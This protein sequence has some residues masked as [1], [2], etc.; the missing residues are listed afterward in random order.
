M[1]GIL[2]LFG[3]NILGFFAGLVLPRKLRWR[4]SAVFWPLAALVNAPTCIVLYSI[5]LQ[6]SWRLENP[7]DAAI[8]ATIIVL[9]WGT[10]G[11]GLGLIL[12]LVLPEPVLSEAGRRMRL[13]AD[14]SFWKARQPD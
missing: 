6:S 2:F 7:S 11:L 12:W 4:P 3:P 8:I 14:P 9:F 5:I 1:I 10:A 13:I